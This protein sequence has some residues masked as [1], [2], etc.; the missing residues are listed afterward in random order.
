MLRNL[1]ESIYTGVLLDVVW[2]HFSDLFLNRSQATLHYNVDLLSRKF[3][4]FKFLLYIT[5]KLGNLFKFTKL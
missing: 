2:V 4:L 1:H 5:T 3:L